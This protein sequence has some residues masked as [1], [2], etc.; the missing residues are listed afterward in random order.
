[1][2]NSVISFPL[3]L[4]GPRGE[5]GGVGRG[6]GSARADFNLRELPCYLS[7]TYE[8]LP[9]L[10]KIIGEQDSVKKIVKGTVVGKNSFRAIV[11]SRFVSCIILFVRSRT[12]FRASCI[13]IY[14]YGAR[15]HEFSYEI[16]F[17]ILRDFVR[18]IVWGFTR[19]RTFA[20]CIQ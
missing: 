2:V 18:D 10:L 7:N 11:S 9:L 15:A 6:G 17:G 16:S 3:T 4:S 1:M 5:G 19:F 13:I 12:R 8:T 14:S 20:C